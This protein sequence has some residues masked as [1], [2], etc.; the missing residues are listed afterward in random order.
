VTVV[1][2]TQAGTYSLGPA[3]TSDTTFIV[4]VQGANPRGEYFL[5]ENREAV[6]ADTAVIADH[7]TVSGNP[8][9]CG[10][11]LMIWHVDS[12]QVANNGFLVSNLV[13]YGPVHGVELE[14]ADGLSNLDRNPYT[15]PLSNRGDAGDP[16]PGTTGNASF[17]FGT[18]PAATKNS[19]GSFVGFVIDSI[20]RLSVQGPVSFRLRFGAATTV[21]ASDTQALVQ[22]DGQSYHQFAALFDSTTT[23]TV[24]VANTQYRPDSL[25]RWVFVS[26]S[27]GQPITHT[28]TS[29]LAGTSLTATLARAFR[30]RFGTS[31]TGAV[32][33]GPTGTANDAFL[34]DGSNVQL[35]AHPGSGLSFLGWSGDTTAADTLLSLL[36]NQ[37]RVVTA[38]FG[39]PLSAPEVLQELFTGTSPLTA[40]Q[41]RYVNALANRSDSTQIDVGGF[42][43]WVRSAHPAPPGTVD[44][45]APRQTET[46]P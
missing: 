22:V 15:D 4:R 20:Q 43:A 1:P 2:L 11:G 27:D 5:L 29:S 42:L 18:D 24:A 25:V 36:M 16:Y 10:G 3:P 40:A 19:D 41:I 23:H 8:P 9:N 35:T 12:E 33:V 31:G 37:P 44:R 46:K 39:L 26:W 14:Q 45:L 30:L 21:Q 7:C 6:L 32:T 38:N 34:A 17:G 13:N 28:F